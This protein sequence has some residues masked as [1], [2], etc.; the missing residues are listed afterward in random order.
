M[1]IQKAP[2]SYETGELIL[3]IHRVFTKPVQMCTI[4][5]TMQGLNFFLYQ[6]Y[7][8]ISYSMNFLKDPHMHKVSDKVPGG[9]IA[10]MQFVQ[11][12]T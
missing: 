5:E 6:N 7:L 11:W 2:T 8:L 4:K 12:R 9:N 3:K 1:G 10:R